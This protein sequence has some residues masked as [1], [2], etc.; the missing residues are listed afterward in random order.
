MRGR[1]GT[2][3][4]AVV[5][6]LGLLLFWFVVVNPKRGELTDVKAQIA[7]EE[8]K[9]QQLT[10]ELQRLEALQEN[11]AKLQ[12]ELGTIRR[13]VPV[14][15][16]LANFIVQVQDAANSA[17]L[18]FVQISPQLPKNPPEGAALAEV[19]ASIQAKGGY[20]A[21]Q[22]FIRRLYG[23]DRALRA[24]T[25]SIGVDTLEPFGTRLSM[26]I[27]AR[28]FYEPPTP[29]AVATPGAPVPGATPVP[30]PTVTTSP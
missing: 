30:T 24:D 4:A 13:Y 1:T 12:A 6:F 21:L 29:V 23:L 11:A 22:D 5:A 14:R 16:E 17:G 7:A 8:V 2:I 20:F 28:V 18:D 19:S 3:V 10:A 9:T 25:V 27:T 15:P 26:Q